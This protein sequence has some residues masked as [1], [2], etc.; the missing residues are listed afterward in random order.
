M[1]KLLK[2][3][4]KLML[5]RKDTMICV[6]MSAVLALLEVLIGKLN[7]SLDWYSMF[8]IPL[9]M[10]MFFSPRLYPEHHTQQAHRGT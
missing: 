2:V 9:I 8:E 10:M 6:I 1:N 4:L 7:G 3:N 5:R